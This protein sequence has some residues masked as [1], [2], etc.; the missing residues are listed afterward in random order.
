MNR[1]DCVDLFRLRTAVAAL[2]WARR[3][4]DDLD[5]AGVAR[6]DAA[7]AY[8]HAI[9]GTLGGELGASCRTLLSARADP[10]GSRRVTAIDRLAALTHVDGDSA[11]ALASLVDDD[12][13]F[14][15]RPPSLFDPEP[16]LDDREAVND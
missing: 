12:I 1:D 13:S 15:R 4:P 9:Q 11:A 10:T 16:D 2:Y 7:V 5:E 14:A 6:V 8:L 3:Q